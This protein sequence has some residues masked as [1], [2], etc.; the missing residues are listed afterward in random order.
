[1]SVRADVSGQEGVRAY[2]AVSETR[3]TVAL[4]N[5]NG[6][7]SDVTVKLGNFEPGT[8]ASLYGNKGGSDIAKL[9]DVPVA[10]GQVTV[11]LDPVSIAMLVVNGKNPNDLPDPGT[12]GAGGGAGGSGGVGGEGGN[13]VDGGSQGSCGCR[14]AGDPGSSLMAGFGSVL[15][16]AL[17]GLR[18]RSARRRRNG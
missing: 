15:A 18:K 8:T 14:L 7:S 4:V 6:A 2:A 1:V 5:E 10:D 13:K 16:G 11:Q 3:M 17:L 12:G 9:A